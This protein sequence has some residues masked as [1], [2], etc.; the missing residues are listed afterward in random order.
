VLTIPQVALEV[1]GAAYYQR[2]LELEISADNAVGRIVCSS[3]GRWVT[4]VGTA[5]V[6]LNY[7]SAV[8]IA[9]I[10]RM[11]PAIFNETNQIF[12]AAGANAILA[13]VTIPLLVFT[14]TPEYSPNIV[15]SFAQSIICAIANV[16]YQELL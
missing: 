12:T 11:L 16:G 3:Q 15:V 1:F 5:L 8:Y 13:L 4:M 2:A 9:W 6:C 14:N 10:S 7:L